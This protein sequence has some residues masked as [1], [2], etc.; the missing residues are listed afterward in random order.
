[1]LRLIMKLTLI[2]FALIVFLCNI[3]ISLMLWDKRGLED[4]CRL[5][6][7]VWSKNEPLNEY[8]VQLIITQNLIK[9]IK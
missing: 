7:V 9:W 3:F 5:F 8:D 6:D 4:C 1:M 2:P